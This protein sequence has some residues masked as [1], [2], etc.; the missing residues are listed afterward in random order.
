VRVGLPL[1]RLRHFQL[2]PTHHLGNSR[3]GETKTLRGNRITVG[4]QNQPRRQLRKGDRSHQARSTHHRFVCNRGFRIVPSFGLFAPKRAQD[5]RQTSVTA[6][7]MKQNIAK[8]R[9]GFAK[10]TRTSQ[11]RSG[12]DKTAFKRQDIWDIPLHSVHLQRQDDRGKC[13]G[14]SPSFWQIN[15]PLERPALT[16][17]ERRNPNYPAFMEK[18]RHNSSAKSHCTPRTAFKSL[19]LARPTAFAQG[20]EMLP[21]GPLAPAP[22]TRPHRQWRCA[23]GFSRVFARYVCRWRNRWAFHRAT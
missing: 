3:S 6:A 2:L 21:E 9:L 16:A 1:A 20:P 23:N 12:C 14:Q 10:I 18:K 19:R 13:Q 8:R 5:S 15:F 4:G 11:P 22:N 17:P 7:A